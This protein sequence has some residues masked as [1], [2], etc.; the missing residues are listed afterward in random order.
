MF[1]GKKQKLQAL[2]ALAG[3][4]A[5]NAMAAVPTEVTTAL[6]DAKTDGVTVATAVLVA[7]VAIFAFKLMR[8]GL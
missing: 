6:G 2:A 8:R 7:I 4:A 5:G 1:K 3:V